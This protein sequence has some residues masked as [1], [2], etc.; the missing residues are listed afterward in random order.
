M[1]H[2]PTGVL[3]SIN[4]LQNIYLELTKAN[5]ATCSHL[6]VSQ[7]RPRDTIQMNRVRQV[8]MMDL[9]VAEIL[10]VTERPKKLKP[11]ME[12]MI[13]MLVKA[14]ARLVNIWR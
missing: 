11:P 7:P 10:L 2:R 4:P 8:S 5:P 14:I 3:V 13:A 1:F 6:K 9:E 12:N